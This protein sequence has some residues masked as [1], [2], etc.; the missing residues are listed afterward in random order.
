MAVETQ[1]PLPKV[2][3]VKKTRIGIKTDHV[4]DISNLPPI[5]HPSHGST[6]GQ[7]DHMTTSLKLIGLSVMLISGD[8]TRPG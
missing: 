5:S 2:K 6:P 7:V 1:P 4:E 8:D 3:Q